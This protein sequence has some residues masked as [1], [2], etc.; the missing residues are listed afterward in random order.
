MSRVAL[1]EK[2]LTHNPKAS[3][4]W[5]HKKRQKPPGKPI[6]RMPTELELAIIKELKDENRAA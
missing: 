6:L 5:P 3:H 4:D 1:P 2:F